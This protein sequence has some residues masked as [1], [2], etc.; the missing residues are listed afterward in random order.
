MC[1]YILYNPHTEKFVDQPHAGKSVHVNG[2]E[3]TTRNISGVH[4]GKLSDWFSSV[5][6]G[7]P[8]AAFT[9]YLCNVCEI[10]CSVWLRRE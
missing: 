3:V 1:N 8:Y 6:L 4:S 10:E 2:H 5:S 7:W 9:K